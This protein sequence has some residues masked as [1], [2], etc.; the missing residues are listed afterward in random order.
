[1]SKVQSPK[2]RERRRLGGIV[3]VLLLVLEAMSCVGQSWTNLSSL[4]QQPF[5]FPLTNATTIPPVKKTIDLNPADATSLR[6]TIKAQV[7]VEG[8]G[9][10]N[11]SGTNVTLIATTSDTNANAFN[12]YSTTDD[13]VYVPLAIN[14]AGGTITLSNQLG[15][16]Y[17]AAT[18]IDTNGV[19]AESDFTGDL[20]IPPPGPVTNVITF[21]FTRTYT[22]PAGNRFFR[23]QTSSNL[24]NWIQ[25]A[26][27]VMTFTNTI[28]Q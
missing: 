25:D 5:V 8:S 9:P 23:V 17:Y 7:L 24:A 26:D 20:Q 2:P 21:A 3:L 15:T 6:H 1:M 13:V 28:L 11:T 10:T 14:V 4:A 22:N 12:F 19:F 27:C 16:N 18:A